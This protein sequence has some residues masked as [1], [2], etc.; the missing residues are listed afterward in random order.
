MSDGTVAEPSLNQPAPATGSVY[1]DPGVTYRDNEPAVVL[2]PA[3]VATY[4]APPS[5][6]VV[7]VQEPT[8]LIG[9]TR[10]PIKLGGP[11][12]DPQG[13]KIYSPRDVR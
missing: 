7:Y 8:V 10:G 9:N 1:V 2:S 5:A 6:A 11:K 3:P 12:Y 4:V 13:R